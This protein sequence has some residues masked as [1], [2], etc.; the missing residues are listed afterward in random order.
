MPDYF[1][2]RFTIE[3]VPE[4]S[5]ILLMTHKKVSDFKV[6]LWKAS[7]LI[8]NDVERNFAT[9]GGLVGGWA[10]LAAST[11]AGRLREGYGGAHPILQRTGALRKSFYAYAD[12]KKAII[13]SKSPYF[14]FHQSRAAR[15]KLPRR[16]MLLLVERTR[17]N[18]VEEFHKF[19]MFK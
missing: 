14:G 1:R 4:L 15:T 8:L 13:T 11:V 19:L 7:K 12:S 16:V 3:G 9:E 17:Q 6:P 2:L 5:R 10:P 18:I